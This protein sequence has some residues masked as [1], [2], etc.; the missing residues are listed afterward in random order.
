MYL[1]DIDFNPQKPY[2][3]DLWP[4]LNQHCNDL[5]ANVAEYISY[6]FNNY[7]RNVQP[8]RVQKSRMLMQ[9][10]CSKATVE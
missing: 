10:N 2:Y 3:Y 4:K 8:S 1:L 5:R 7:G 9:L 6:T